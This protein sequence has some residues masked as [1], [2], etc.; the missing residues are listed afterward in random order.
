MGPG[1]PAGRGA[2]GGGHLHR[3]A[4]E[5][6]PAC[7]AC[8]GIVKLAVVLFGQHLDHGTL[9]QAERI[10]KASQLLLAVGSSLQVEPVA[11]LC[12]VAVLAGARLVIVNRDPTPY[13]GMADALVREPISTALP[14]I[15]AALTAAQAV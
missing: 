11:S 5:T 8:G 14:R 6:D 4:G 12:R 7:P 2:D 10:A 1:C 3:L 15:T 13:D 9:A